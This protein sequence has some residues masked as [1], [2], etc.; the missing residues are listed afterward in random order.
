MKGLL[1][2]LFVKLGLDSKEFEKG[3]DNAKG[4][5]NMFA[6]GIKRL[7]GMMAAAFSVAAI[8]AFVKS[9][10][11]A[12]KES[13]RIENELSAAIKANGKDVQSTLND[14]K[15]FA[16]QLQ[17]NSTIE[18]ETTLGLIR[19]AETMQSKAPKEAAQNAIALSKALGIDLN[20]AVKMA[21]MAQGDMYTMLARYTPALREAGTEAERTAAYNKL[22]ASGVQM[23][24]DELNT[25]P[26][27]LKQV[28]NAWGDLKEEWGKA[29]IEGNLLLE[30]IGD[31]GDYVAVFSDPKF[32]TFNFFKAFLG[33]DEAM[34]KLAEQARQRIQLSEAA[35]KSEKAAFDL[36]T[37]GWN[38]GTTAVEKHVETIADLKQKTSDLEASIDSYGIT[39]TAEI[40]N[41]LRQIDANKKLIES[42]TTLQEKHGK[43]TGFD[44]MIKPV[45]DIGSFGTTP[46]QGLETD[47]LADYGTDKLKQAAAEQKAIQDE[48]IAQW[49]DFKMQMAQVAVDFGIEVVD[50]LGQAFGELA[51]TGKFPDDFGENVLSII[52]GFISQLGKMLIGLGVASEAFQLLLKSAFTNPVSAGLAIAAGAALVLLGGA[53]SGFAKSGPTGAGGGYSGVSSQ[54]YSG[55][56]NRTN[57]GTERGGEVLFKIRGTE[58]VGVLSNV[59]RKNLNIG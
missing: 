22:L 4:K 5:T 53:I 58:L 32:S 11:E 54:S 2:S 12:G 30:L 27:R 41:T 3:V 23:L 15:A 45:T 55:A 48:F 7:G 36:M 28:Q 52:G 50:E 14:Y 10:I 8:T 46:T 37:K 26:G 42:L 29:I 31:L 35:A 59:Q 34:K 25:A 19:L 20:T 9:A 49:D 16:S 13:I 17:R 21:V 40:Q 38:S 43:V 18:D 47:K 57:L 51:R 44:Y 39:Q 1:A 6:D 33:G 24:S 56:T